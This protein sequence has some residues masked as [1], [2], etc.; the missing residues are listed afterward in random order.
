M[1]KKFTF[2]CQCAR[3]CDSSLQ[4]GRRCVTYFISP[5]SFRVCCPTSCFVLVGWFWTYLYFPSWLRLFTSTLL[6]FFAFRL[7]VSRAAECVFELFHPHLFFLQCQVSPL[8]VWSLVR[9]R[10][11]LYLSRQ[12]DG[13]QRGHGE[14]FHAR[15]M[16]NH[17]RVCPVLS[18]KAHQSTCDIEF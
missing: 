1:L 10:R 18:V 15:S 6:S 16:G 3:L 7:Q 8:V 4:R 11:V 13:R 17:T 2:F 9:R 5:F 12:S 14:K